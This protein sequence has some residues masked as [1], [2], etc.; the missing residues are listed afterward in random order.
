[1]FMAFLV[2]RLRGRH[3]LAAGEPLEQP[4]QP[5]HALAKAGHVAAELAQARDDQPGEHGAGADDGD[6]ERDR[7][8]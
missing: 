2:E 6:D 3:G 1:M 8:G 7:V 4:F 5:C